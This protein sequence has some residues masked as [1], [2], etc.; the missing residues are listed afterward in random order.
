MFDSLRLSRSDCGLWAVKTHA[1][2]HSLLEDSYWRASGSSQ[3]PLLKIPLNSP[4]QC[5]V[6]IIIYYQI[7]N[8]NNENVFLEHTILYPRFTDADIFWLSRNNMMYV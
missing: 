5:H 2:K 6:C 1:N 8:R 3:Q 7:M 4:L